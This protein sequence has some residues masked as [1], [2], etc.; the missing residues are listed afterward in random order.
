MK[1]IIDRRGAVVVAPH[2]GSVVEFGA[3]VFAA[4]LLHSNRP[5]RQEIKLQSLEFRHQV[6]LTAPAKSG[7]S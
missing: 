3:A 2:F 1:S 4:S 7:N 6:S 5:A